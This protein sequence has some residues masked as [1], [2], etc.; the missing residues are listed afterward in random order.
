[1]FFKIKTV[2][3]QLS[4]TLCRVKLRSQKTFCQSICVSD[5]CFTWCDRSMYVKV[6]A[7][8]QKEKRKCRVPAMHHSVYACQHRRFRKKNRYQI[9]YFK[10]SGL[11]TL[12]LLANQM[13][14]QVTGIWN[15]AEAVLYIQIVAKN[16][17]KTHC[18]DNILWLKVAMVH[19]LTC[20]ALLVNLIFFFFYYPCDI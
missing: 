1:M 19:L 17:R 15:V 12:L 7:L 9:F 13:T 10:T 3:L 20:A 14:G 5:A 18:L 6:V 11:C 4:L 16:E 8:E 2:E